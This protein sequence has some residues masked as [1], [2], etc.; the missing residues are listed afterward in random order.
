MVVDDGHVRHGYDASGEPP[1]VQGVYAD[2]G[3]GHRG[4]LDVD[5]AL[6]RLLVDEDVQDAAV[7]VALLDYVVPDLGVPVWIAGRG[8]LDRVEHVGDEETLSRYGRGGDLLAHR[9][10]AGGCGGYLQP[11]ALGELGHQ[12][13]T[14]GGAQIDPSSV[15]YVR[16]KLRPLLESQKETERAFQ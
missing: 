15:Y 2:G 14:S 3:D 13:E 6:G 8:R 16:I 4:T 5:V 11:G 1:A 12:L 9:E 10:R 7:L